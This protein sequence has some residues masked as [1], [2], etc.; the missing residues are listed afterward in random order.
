M[1]TCD[2]LASSMCILVLVLFLLLFLLF[3]QQQEA[4]LACLERR[5][6]AN[7]KNCTQTQYYFLQS[8]HKISLSSSCAQSPTAQSCLQQLCPQTSN[9]ELLEE[10]CNGVSPRF[11]V[12]GTEFI[13]TTTTTTTTTTNPSIHPSIHPSKQKMHF[14][15]TPPINIFVPILSLATK[16]S[17]PK[18]LPLD[19]G[20]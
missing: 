7:S 14:V 3:L 12:F 1:G 10:K 6:H 9:R 4:A 13:Q 20:T 17:F 19:F 8:Q 18:A 16:N 2:L 11:R 5:W 15:L